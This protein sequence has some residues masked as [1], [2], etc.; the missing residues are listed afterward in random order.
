MEVYSVV[1]LNGD[2]HP[3]LEAVVWLLEKQGILGNPDLMKASKYLKSRQPLKT[4]NL[5]YE[6]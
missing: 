6:G 3:L 4:S 1:E 5:F 2:E